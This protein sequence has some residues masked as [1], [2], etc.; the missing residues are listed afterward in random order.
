MEIDK[1]K[2]FKSFEE[3]FKGLDQMQPE[4]IVF[5]GDYLS[6]ESVEADAYEKLQTNFE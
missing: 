1:A 2:H 4:I 3:M 6:Q 5:I